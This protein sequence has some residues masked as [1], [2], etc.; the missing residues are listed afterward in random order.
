MHVTFASHQLA[1]RAKTTINGRR[2]QMEAFGYNDGAVRATWARSP[3]ESA[4]EDLREQDW[5]MWQLHS[6]DVHTN[7]DPAIPPLIYPDTWANWYRTHYGLASNASW[8]FD[9]TPPIARRRSTRCTTD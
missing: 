2:H 6:F 4:P 8:S 7:H 3:P 1:E 9:S 5:S